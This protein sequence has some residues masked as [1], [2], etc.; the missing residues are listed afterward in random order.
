MR[1][2]APYRL[3]TV[4]PSL[5]PYLKWVSE[6]APESPCLLLR[7]TLTRP[8]PASVLPL[9]RVSMPNASYQLA[10][11][12]SVLS[13]SYG[14]PHY[15]LSCSAKRASS[16]AVEAVTLQRCGLATAA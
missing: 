6:N 14:S 15:G 4:A 16:M 10:I 12:H 7:R 9:V 13:S 5:T 3:A 2:S 11:L 8:R 1:F